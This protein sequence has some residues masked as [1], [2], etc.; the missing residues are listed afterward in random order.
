[1]A[2]VTI[3]RVKMTQPKSP[4]QRG[5]RKL[6]ADASRGTLGPRTIRVIPSPRD[7]MSA[8]TMVS[9]VM[10]PITAYAQTS[11]CMPAST[12]VVNAG[13]HAVAGYQRGVGTSG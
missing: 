1:M 11:W 9:T 4:L 3:S 10:A 7:A 6:R 5:A 12:D 2:A 8:G 13:G